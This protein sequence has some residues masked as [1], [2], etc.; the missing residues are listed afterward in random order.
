MTT[1]TKWIAANSVD[2]AGIAGFALSLILAVSQFIANRLKVKATS[3]ILIDAPEIPG[4]VFFHV[5]LY[6]QTHLPFSLVDIRIDTGHN[7]KDVPIERTV[8]TYFF[9]GE[10]GRK[11]PAGPV[12]L[13]P[14]FPVRF[15]SY[16]AD[17]LLLEVLRR[18][19]DM[20]ILPPDSHSQEG[21]PHKRSLQF[22][23][24]CRRL[25][26]LHL[27]LRTSRGSTSIPVRVESVQGWDWL[28]TYAV[29]KAGNEGK[30][31]FPL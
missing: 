24:P 3:C 14:A 4:S 30:I 5:C 7:H 15:D 27:R 28:E 22:H 10:P 26:P 21:L 12:V 13:S 20:K 17:V 29:Q 19:I 23:R 2:I 18:H 6:N 31:S 25:S 11:A 16:A 8:R 1:I 9:K